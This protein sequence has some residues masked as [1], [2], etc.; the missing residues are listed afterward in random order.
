ML[1][2]PLG[3]RYKIIT[4]LGVGGFGQTYLAEDTQQPDSF[5]CVVK[6]FKPIGQDINFLEVARR[7]FDTEIETLRRLGQH[8]QIPQLFDFLRRI[9]NSI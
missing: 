1:G 5:Q 8:D 2:T 9:E 3:G 6:Q 4:E 7:L